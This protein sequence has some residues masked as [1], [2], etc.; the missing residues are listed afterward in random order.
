M[1]ILNKCGKS[2]TFVKID[3][4][5]AY[6]QKSIAL[7]DRRIQYFEW[8]GRYFVELCLVF[9]CSTSVGIYDRFAKVI[10]FI[11]LVGSL[12]QLKKEYLN[13]YN[14]PG[15]PAITF[16]KQE[17]PFVPLAED[18]WELP[19]PVVLLFVDTR[20]AGNVS[21]YPESEEI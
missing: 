2:C 8:L 17:I 1:K 9:G 16:C 7:E 19:S 15:F 5:A 13:N 11:A 21:S 4:A 3:W 10:L 20:T 18:D 14:E 6:K 12:D